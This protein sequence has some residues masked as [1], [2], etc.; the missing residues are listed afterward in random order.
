MISN[1]SSN[2]F[3]EC[4]CPV[5]TKMKTNC[6]RLNEHPKSVQARLHLKSAVSEHAKNAD[7]ESSVKLSTIQFGVEE[8]IFLKYS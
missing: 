8:I 1:V 3:G 5:T 4:F 6:V 2:V 7:S